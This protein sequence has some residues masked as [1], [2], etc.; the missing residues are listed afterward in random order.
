MLQ[1][2]LGQRIAALRK[3]QGLTQEAL[4]EVIGCSVE[5]I[6]LVERG[7]NA[8]AVAGLQGFADALKVEVR[9]LFTF[10]AKKPK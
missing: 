9:D 4:A 5:F 10:E 7:V 1:K 3:K 2:K 6:S 8:P